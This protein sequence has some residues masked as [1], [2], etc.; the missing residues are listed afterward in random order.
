M[1]GHIVRHG[2]TRGG[3]VSPE[4]RAWKSM[5]NRC[6]LPSTK[7]FESWGGRGIKVCARWRESFVNFLADVGRRPKSPRHTLG[8]IDND[9]HYSCGKC[10]QCRAEGWPANCAWQTHLEQQNNKSSNV[11][12]THAGLTLTMAEWA[13]RKGMRLPALWRRLHKDGM[14]LEEA[15]DRPI[16]Q[17]RLLTHDGLTLTVSQWAKRI[18]MSKTSLW[19]RLKQPGAS[20]AEALD[21]PAKANVTLTHGGL[22]LTLSEWARRKGMAVRTLGTRLENGWSVEEALEQPLRR[23]DG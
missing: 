8:R 17:D 16:Q 13:R 22:T 4:W 1:A 5:R 20:I 9:G 15:L 21:R 18:G 10:V 19:R 2:E 3:V 23:R 11:R 6:Y 14:T 12:L 7:N